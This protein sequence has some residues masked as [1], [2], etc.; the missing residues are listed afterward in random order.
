M[1]TI[2]YHVYMYIY[3]YIHKHCI[4]LYIYTVITHV[5]TNVFVEEDIRVLILLLFVQAPRHSEARAV[6]NSSAKIDPAAVDQFMPLSSKKTNYHQDPCT[7]IKGPFEISSHDFTRKND[8]ILNILSC[9]RRLQSSPAK[10]D[11]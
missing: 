11:N 3:K 2:S 5:C 7:R 6:S 1:N 10:T 4:C 9:L 8:V